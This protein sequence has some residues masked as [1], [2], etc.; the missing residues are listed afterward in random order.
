MNLTQTDY[1]TAI[2][3]LERAETAEEIL[4]TLGQ[5][6]NCPIDTEPVAEM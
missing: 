1:D 2:Q 3:S 5:L 4:E 6:Q